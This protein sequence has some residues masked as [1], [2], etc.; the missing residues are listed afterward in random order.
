MESFGTI[1]ESLGHIP[2]A[3]CTFLAFI[4]LPFY[5]VCEHHKEL[6]IICI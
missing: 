6:G 4:M 2:N 3:V 5:Y 1:L